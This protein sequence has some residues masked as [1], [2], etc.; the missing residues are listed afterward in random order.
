MY[1]YVMLLNRYYY[2]GRRTDTEPDQYKQIRKQNMDKNFIKVDKWGECLWGIDET[3]RLFINGGQAESLEGRSIPWE[4]YRGLITEAAVIGEVTLPEGASLAELF[5][6]CKGLE[7]ADLSGLNTAG[8]TDMH[9][10][11]E[12]CTRLKELDISSFDTR[13]CSDMSRMFAKC[14][15]LTDI[16]L[17]ENFSLNGDGTTACDRLAVKEAGKYRRARVISAEGCLIR[18]HENAGRDIFVERKSVPD[19]RYVIEN[20]MYDVPGERLV[21][22]GWN[23]EADGSGRMFRPEQELNSVDEDIDLYAIWASAPEIGEVRPVDE[24]AFGQ[25]IPFELPEIVSAG[26]PNVTGFLEVSPNGEEGTWQA[27]DHNTVLPVTCNGWLVR[28]CAANSVGKTYSNAVEL[29]IKKAAKDMSGVR[30]SEEPDM[31]YDGTPKHVWLE[32]LPVGVTAEYDGNS[33]TEAGTYTARVR[34]NYDEDNF[35]EPTLQRE[36]EWSIKK[37]VYDMSNVRWDYSDSFVYDGEARQVALT[38]LPDGVTA[39]YENNRAVNSGIYTAT[40]ALSYDA[41]NYEKPADI[42]PCVWEIEKAVIDPLTLEWSEYDKFVYDGT[43][44]TVRIL[45]L[46]EDAEVEYDGAEETPA[47]KYLARA[48]FLGNYR[49]SGPAEYEWE[50]TKA[51][52][53]MGVARWTYDKPFDFD[54]ETHSVEL[55]GLPEELGV[56]YLSNSGISA[57]DYQAKA[58]FQNPDTHNYFT[59]DDMSLTWSIRKKSLDMSGVRWDYPGAF[60]YDGENKKVELTGLPEGIHV[61]YENASAFNAGVYNAHAILEYDSDNMYAQQPADCQWKINKQRFDISG[62]YWDYEEAFTYD[63]REHGV[64]LAGLPEGLNVEYQDNHKVEAGKYVATAILTP[65]DPLN[66]EAPEINGCTWAINKA[67]IEKPGLEWTDCTDFIYDGTDK[68]VEIISDIGDDLKVEYACNKYHNAGRYYA[69]AIFTPVDENNYLPPKPLGY[70][71][72]IGKA[73]A[74]VAGAVWDYT[75]AFTYDGSRKSVKL[76]GV[77]EGV[78]VSYTNASATEAGDYTA[79]AKFSVSDTANFNTSIP[80]MTLDWSIEKAEYDL[81]NAKWQEERRFTYDGEEKEV[82]LTGLPDGL[83]PVYSGNRAAAAGV[84][85]AQAT[86]EFD[87][88][89]FERPEFR[90]CSWIIDKAPVDVSGVTW[91]YEKPFVYDGTEKVIYAQYI[92]EGCYAVYSNAR[93]SNAGTYVGTADIRPEDT[94]NY[95]PVRIDN[96][97]WRIEKGDYDMSHA[98]WDYDRPFTYDGAE[99]G[100]VLKGLP[101]GVTPAYRNNTATDAGTYEASVT[102]RA[103]DE[104][105]Y[106]VPEM[107]GCEWTISKADYDMSS[108]QWNYGGEFSYTGRMHEIELRGLPEGVRAVYSG[109]AAAETGVYEA[110][111]DLIPFDQS[112]YNK[113]HVGS[114]RWQI[115][116]ADYEMSAVRWDYTDA[117]V[118]N[119]RVQGV[120]LEQLPNGVSADYRNNEAVNAGK[121]TARAI[122]RVSDEANYNVPSVQDCDWEIIKADYNMSGAEWD[123]QEGAFTYDGDRKKVELYNLPENVSASYD[124]NTGVLAGDYV[125]TAAFRTTDANFNAPESVTLPWSIGKADFDMSGARW[126]YT[127]EFVYDGTPK[128]VEITG[129]PEGLSVDYSGNTATDA[130]VYEAVARFISNTGNFSVPEPMSC[131]WTINKADPDIRRL[132]WDYSQPFVYDGTVKTIELAGIPETLEVSYTG[133][134]AEVVG[135]YN[136]HAEL[137]PV[138]PDNYNY[139]SI[140]DCPWNIVKAEYDMSDARWTGEMR[141]VYDGTEKSVTLTGLPEGVEPVYSGNSAV[142]AGTYT[143]SA[144]LRYDERNY[145]Q[146]SVGTVEWTIDKAVYDMTGVAWDYNDSFVYNGGERK[147][148]LTGLPAGV[149]AAY[150]GNTGINAGDYEAS[151][152]FSYDEKNY[153][154]PEFGPVRWHIGMADAPVDTGNIRWNYTGPFVYDGTPKSVALAEKAVEQGFLDKLRGKKPVMELEGVPAGF[155]VVYEDNVKTDA[156]VYYAKAKLVN[157]EDTNYREVTVP[158]CRWE[159]TKAGIDMSEVHWDYSSPFIYDGEEKT[160][161]LAGLPENV[162]VTYTGNTAVNA[163]E[164][165]AMAEIEAADPVNF[166]TPEPV[167]GC[168]WKISKASYDMSG[169]RWTYDD[170][171]IYNGEEKSVKVIGLPEGVRIDAYRGN[172]AI[173]AG[174]YMA[175]AILEYSNKDNYEEPSIANL[176]WRIQKKK[177]NTSDVRWDYDESTL[178]VYDEK[179]KKVSLIG[180]PKDAEVVYVDNV[181]INAGTYTARARLTYDTRNCEAEEIADLKWKIDKANYDTEHV[182]WSYDKPFVYD[183]YEKSIV[184]RNVPKS[185]DVRYRDNKAS[186]VGTYT[187]KAYLTYDSDNYNAPEIDTT[188]DW[189]IVSGDRD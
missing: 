73:D 79:I 93:A 183:A 126:D 67:Q 30:W 130:G 9:S 147:V 111:A 123:Y 5:K 115:V 124:G 158:E 176:K 21:F 171:I 7:A 152:E 150:A 96:I 2:I 71:W 185:I 99:H 18:Y 17:G 97:T 24:F 69:K 83:E 122:L 164:Y 181:K 40:A 142:D 146:P 55:T 11:F 61:D 23:T 50:I 12:G 153:F 10:M 51:S 143:A 22:M 57:G 163:G 162:T 102:F 179:P 43:P 116:K 107:G 6:G 135:T 42:T 156:G 169:A 64:Y 86:F 56:R 68:E 155:D 60:T 48:S 114:C 127:G 41:V 119:G 58:I 29:H 85:M 72:S 82:V 44:K 89:N 186:A 65:S 100:V 129:L 59:P 16:L 38:G 35:S 109:N 160:V 49:V 95:T 8:V 74:D 165:E 62:V 87:E 103:A 157:P 19:F 141:Y 92:P 131:T 46:P 175:E 80:D 108:V 113:P 173:D 168:W 132:R 70:S 94:D 104:R 184:L 3:G 13:S 148:E 128:R 174:T 26:D 34:L 182:H 63:G 78:Q 33:A 32:G 14:A 118:Y 54:R 28:L 151:A 105:N 1:D 188:I 139:P 178:F 149:T 91:A 144:S 31:T 76:S 187:A 81:R 45:N 180:L 90:E 145:R 189:A 125:A 88:K 159:I 170:D 20:L 84:Y 177:I 77:P 36:Y 53:D 4:S 101:E 133:N 154:R 52:Y 47:G 140:A 137:R 15:R 166:E 136:A 37:S 167:R 172:T 121:Y 112:N 106:N 120:M 27:I 75:S 161:E 25:P 138:N 134:T 110:T 117:K 39:N 66:Y 98:Y